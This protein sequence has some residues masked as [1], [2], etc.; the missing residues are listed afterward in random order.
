MSGGRCSLARLVKIARNAPCPCGSGRKHKL[1][2]GTTR[3]EERER[4]RLEAVVEEATRVARLFPR[5]R[6]AGKAFSA[7]A[8]R[9]AADDAAEATAAEALAL[10]E[11][12]DRSRITD[13]LPGIRERYCAELGDERLAEQALLVGAVA[14][15]VDERLPP[16]PRRLELLEEREDL[17][18]DP[19]EVLALALEAGGLW[20]VVESA[21]LETALRGLP[22]E[23]DDEE[24]E[25][26]WE[27]IVAAEAKRLANRWHKR[28]LAELVGRLASQLPFSDYPA[29]SA[30]LASACA[31]F[32]RDRGVRVRL[33]AALL[34]DSLSVSRLGLLAA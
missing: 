26:H 33:A 4:A 13:G 25:E 8:D 16:D 10:L 24:Y 15:A 9:V 22:E 18:S 27:A 21:Q 12:A 20:G 6:P 3:E 28:R 7:W 30:A 11:P 23:R 2:C 17:R 31:A 29:A 19:V 5:L 1:C 32:E 14:A 34:A